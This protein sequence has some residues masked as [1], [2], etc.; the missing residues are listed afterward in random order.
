[1]ANSPPD[2]GQERPADGHGEGRLNPLLE[3]TEVG[4]HVSE[5]E[6]GDGDTEN[7]ENNLRKPR[8]PR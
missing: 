3:S 5:D 1:M 8:S 4:G 6:V 7:R 2:D